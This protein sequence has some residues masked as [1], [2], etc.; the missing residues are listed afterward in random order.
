[1]MSDELTLFL[2]LFAVLFSAVAAWCKTLQEREAD[3][4]RVEPREAETEADKHCKTR[5]PN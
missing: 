2:I 4:N 3:K 1:M 5:K